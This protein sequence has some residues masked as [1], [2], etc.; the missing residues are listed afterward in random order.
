[1]EI[2]L[3]NKEAYIDLKCF[4]HIL[5]TGSVGTGKSYTIFNIVAQICDTDRNARVIYLSDD[6]KDFKKVEYLCDGSLI[7]K[8]HNMDD[9]GSL[10]SLMEALY[11]QNE[12][13]VNFLQDT[14]CCRLSDVDSRVKCYYINNK[15]H[16]PDEIVSY[17][18][19]NEEKFGLAKDYSDTT[20]DAV[21]TQ[22]IKYYPTRTCVIIDC[23]DINGCSEDFKHEYWNSLLWVGRLGRSCWQSLI[24]SSRN[25]VY[26]NMPRNLMVNIPIRIMFD[27]DRITQYCMFDKEVSFVKDKFLIDICGSFGTVSIW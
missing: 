25:L 14:G 5:M 13:R 17:F 4:P 21:K 7:N 11:K 9:G 19:D 26:D 3:G 22:E 2:E 1:M 16:M 8:T 15:M 27:G 18:A 23:L 24:F 10:T 12:F 6:S 20:G